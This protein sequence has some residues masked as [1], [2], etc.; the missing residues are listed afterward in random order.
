MAFTPCD[1]VGK[2]N[3]FVCASMKNNAQPI[4]PNGNADEFVNRKLIRP[5]LPP[6]TDAPHVVDTSGSAAA[7]APARERSSEE[8]RERRPASRSSFAGGEQ[9][10]AENFYFQKQMQS[11][12]PMTFVLKNG[13]TV[14][15]IIEW[16]DTRCI[17]V[18]RI[19]RG[20]MLLYKGGIRYLHKTGE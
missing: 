7:A 11:Q 3:G 18:S 5:T 9:T 13:E 15:G 20:S 4:E 19:G 2:L 8:K 6:R 10:H 12:T 16:Y 14:Q 17:K 1:T